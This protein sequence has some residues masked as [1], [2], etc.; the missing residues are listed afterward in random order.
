[1]IIDWFKE[2]KK[3]IAFELIFIVVW[4]SFVLGVCQLIPENQRRSGWFVEVGSALSSRAHGLGS[5]LARHAVR[6]DGCEPCW[7]PSV[8]RPKRDLDQGSSPTRTLGGSDPGR[9]QIV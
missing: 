1:M 8:C 2:N 6:T 7:H 9:A 5:G 4:I 3:V